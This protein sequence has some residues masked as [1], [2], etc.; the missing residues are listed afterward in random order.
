MIL[1]C[2]YSYFFNHPLQAPSLFKEGKPVTTSVCG[3][4][5]SCSE[6]SPTPFQGGKLPIQVGN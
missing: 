2:S 1:G 4:I 6:T 5:R 3:D